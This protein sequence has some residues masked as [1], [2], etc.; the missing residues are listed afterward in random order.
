MEKK[1]KLAGKYDIKDHKLIR[2]D[3]KKVLKAE[4]NYSEQMGIVYFRFENAE[5]YAITKSVDVAPDFSLPLEQA[6]M[7]FEDEVIEALTKSTWEGDC[8]I[9]EFDLKFLEMT[10]ADFAESIFKMRAVEELENL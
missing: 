1:I 3:K 4:I 10:A 6:K 7:A 9:A 2:A 8:P 5:S